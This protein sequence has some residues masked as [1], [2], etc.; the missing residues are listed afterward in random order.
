[1]LILVVGIFFTACQKEDFTPQND[2]VDQVPDISTDGGNDGTFDDDPEGED[3]S[4]SNYKVSGNNISLTKDFD[5]SESLKSYQNDK[6]RHQ[7]MWEHITRLF[8]K[9][10]RYNISEFEV[11]HGG[12]D[13]SGFVAPIDYSDLSKWKLA[14]AI[15]M[16]GDLNDL[17][18]QNF[19]T[20]VA[21]HEFGHILTLN[22][23][24]IDLKDESDC[25]NYFTGEGCST[26]HSY[27]NRLYELGWVDIIDEHDPEYPESTYS[28]YPDR[29]HTDY[30]ATNPGEDIA[31]VFAYFVMAED[32]PPGKNIAEQKVRLLFEYP[33]LVA[34]R[35][36]IRKRV[37][38]ISAKFP[39]S[40][41]RGKIEVCGHK[42][43][44]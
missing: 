5:V 30:A 29:F 25:S 33:E 21:I 22:E 1:M 10:S 13:L 18:F 39:T 11:F 19:Y 23:T 44:K 35:D 41:L 32:I 26:K 4:L 36:E 20:Y 34:I 8:P 27:I 38:P 43:H 42:R 3:G 12:G 9:G 37:G 6:T 31:E 40:S 24:Q 14:M 15:D 2:F 28:K 16:E 17:N 7:K